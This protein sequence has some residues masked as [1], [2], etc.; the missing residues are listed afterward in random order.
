MLFRIPDAHGVKSDLGMTN[1]ST[2]LAPSI[3]RM[4]TLGPKYINRTYI[5]LL[6]APGLRSPSWFVCEKRPC[7][8]CFEGTSRRLM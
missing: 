3:W 4:S 2:F 5:G 8:C 6:G 7:L 1:G